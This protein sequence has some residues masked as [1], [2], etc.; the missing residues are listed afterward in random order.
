MST[1]NTDFEFDAYS[2][3]VS[4]D[5]YPFY[6]TMR[7]HHPV[8]WC[9]STRA[10]ALSRYDD[11]LAAL[12]DPGTFSSAKGNI[13]ND[14]PLR[15]GRT[16][17]TTDP[18]KHDQLRA[19]VNE[20]FARRTV[21]EYEQPMRELAQRAVAD[22]L[23][24]DG[25]VDLRSG[26]AFPSSA[27]V[28]GEVLGV[29][30]TKQASL[31]DAFVVV[32]DEPLRLGADPATDIP[33]RAAAMDEVLGVVRETLEARRRSPGSDVVST[34]LQAGLTD[35]E[36]TWIMFT[37]LGAGLESST[38]QFL[39]AA[40]S[41]AL[42][43]NARARLAGEPTLVPIA[44]EELVRYDCGPN[45]FHR[46]LTKDVELH[47]Q[48]MHAGDS[49]LV[50]YGSA[51]RDERRF[52][53]ADE[54]VID[55]HPNPHLGFG[56]GPH[57]CLGAPLARLQAKVLIETLLATAPEYRVHEDRLEWKVN[58]GFRGVK[59]LPVTLRPPPSTSETEK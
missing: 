30:L 45:R 1:S 20:A 46:T 32:L 19:I 50:M 4:T 9:E 54:L 25:P 56:R 47:D 13:V 17:G 34:L 57:F 36:L 38:A 58:P 52:E 16:L 5:P 22:L 51:N 27:A 2:I 14:N 44:Y 49:V 29:D 7:E 31:A 10:W 15:A 26:L 33:E 37:F 42:H 53:R 41:L 18:P 12:L 3:E 35:D 39:L 11:V 24:F 23:R 48:Q 59:S 55:R 8:L 21:G 6:R 28:L 43:P 40:R